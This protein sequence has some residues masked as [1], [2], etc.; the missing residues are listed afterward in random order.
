VTQIE[1]TDRAKT[2]LT[3]ILSK[4]REDNGAAVAEKW[5]RR[6]QAAIG[7]LARSPE[8]GAPKPRLGRNM[9]MLVVESWLVFYTFEADLV[10]V[11]RALYAAR[12]LTRKLIAET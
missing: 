3:E 9:R 11:K 6:F 12:R 1:V 8:I 7:R 2:D 5:D 4:I 10:I